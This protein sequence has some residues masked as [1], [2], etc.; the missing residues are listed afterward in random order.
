MTIKQL[1]IHFGYIVLM[2]T[3]YILSYTASRAE[4]VTVHINKVVLATCVEAIDDIAIM[5]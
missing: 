5:E 4:L 2:H 1:L 3:L